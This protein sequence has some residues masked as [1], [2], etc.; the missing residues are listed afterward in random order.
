MIDSVFKGTTRSYLLADLVYIHPARRPERIE[1][2]PFGGALPYMDIQALETGNPLRYAEGMDYILKEK[3]L[4]IVKD[5][6]RSGKV[7]RA[8]EG[9]AASTLTILTPRC[10]EIQMGYLY[11]FLSY[12]YEDFQS[13]LRGTT[14][15]HLDMNYLRQM[16]IPIPDDGRQREI[17]EKYQRIENLVKAMKE[18]SASLMELSDKLG[19]NDMKDRC[20]SLSLQGDM[21]LKS[22]LHQVFGRKVI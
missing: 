17:A 7:F 18:K 10:P 16:R 20:K 8:K 1:D 6:H 4:V 11:C 19:S 12:C 9:V 5:G 21:T 15:A 13:R 14:I 2:Y 22:W 3:D